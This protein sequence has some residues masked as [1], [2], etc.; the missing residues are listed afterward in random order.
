MESGMPLPIGSLPDA[1][2][3]MSQAKR[4]KRL[5][6]DSTSPK[7]FFS[8]VSAQHKDAKEKHQKEP[9]CTQRQVVIE[10]HESR[11]DCTKRQDMKEKHESVRRSDCTRRKVVN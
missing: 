11:S 9:D 1:Q 7:G 2:Q 8:S 3:H 4:R 6:F 10:M 5:K